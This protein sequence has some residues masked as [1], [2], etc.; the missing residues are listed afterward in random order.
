MT[1]RP[2][3]MRAE[4]VE[5]P[6]SAR[7]EPVEARLTPRSAADKGLP[8]LPRKPSQ[9]AGIVHLGLSNFHRAHQAVYTGKALD[10][11]EGPWGI[12]GVA[13]QSRDVLDAM[14]DQDRAYAVLSLEGN[15]ADIQVLQAH[16]ELI[17][18]VTDPERVVARL[19]DPAIQ[20][21]TVT[22]TEA[23]YTFD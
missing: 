21:I 18:A 10:L 16:Q 17:L 7:A 23:G 12:V 2:F 20:I 15:S 9:Q 1:G 8:V 13:R 4:P 14:T 3:D 11:E 5:A 19:A 6:K 22:V